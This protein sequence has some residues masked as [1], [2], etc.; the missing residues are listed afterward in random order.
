MASCW[1][2]TFEAADAAYERLTTGILRLERNPCQHGYAEL[3]AR[4][5]RPE[6]TSLAERSE[7]G[8]CCTTC[9]TISTRGTSTA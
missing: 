3:R 8:T 9:S 5:R 6:R 7:C 1:A 4:F 2:S